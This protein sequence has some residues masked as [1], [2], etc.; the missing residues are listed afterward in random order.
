MDRDKIICRCLGISNG[1]I[2]DAVKAGDTTYE[3]VQSS[4]GCGTACGACEDEVRE[5][6]DELTK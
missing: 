2:E 1:D 4:T 3:D 6:I 5:L